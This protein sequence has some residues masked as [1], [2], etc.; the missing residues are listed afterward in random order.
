MTNPKKK[1]G[2]PRAN[3]NAAK[4]VKPLLKRL[5]YGLTVAPD[6]EKVIV[7]AETMV[8]PYEEDLG[9]ALNIT[10]GQAIL[11]DG[12]L[13]LKVA[14]LAVV[15]EMLARGAV[16]VDPLTGAWDL[17]DGLARLAPILSA[18]ARIVKQLGLKRRSRKVSDLQT[19]IELKK[20]QHQETEGTKEG[21]KSNEKQ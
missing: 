17:Q 1:P 5:R 20:Q 10:T 9:G 4:S 11:L 3:Q 14:Q 6:M 2:A 18:Q 13:S 7:L 19:Y 8:A 15:K 21:K 12:L 16:K